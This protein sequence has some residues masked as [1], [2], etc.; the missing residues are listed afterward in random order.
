MDIWELGV[1][2]S[3]GN[4]M[5]LAMIDCFTRWLILIPIRSKSSKTIAAAIL[6]YLITVHG[7]PCQILTDREAGFIAKGIATLCKQLGIRKINTSGIS[8]QANGA[9]DR[10]F[11]TLAQQMTIY[12]GRHC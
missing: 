6:K 2:S 7:I 11:R 8:S 5:V 4:T 9:V 12:A 3:S 1:E 10:V